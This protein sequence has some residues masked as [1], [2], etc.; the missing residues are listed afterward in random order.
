MAISYKNRGIAKNRLGQYQK[1]LL[2]FNEAYRLNSKDVSILLELAFARYRAQEYN[3]AIEVATE[4][5]AIKPNSA[6]AYYIRA[7]VYYE[8]SDNPA[9]A[10]ADFEKAYSL[11]IPRD[12]KPLSSVEN[13]GPV[14]L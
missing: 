7:W 14:P 2:D 12:D 4:A 13:R 6:R 10:S 3:L 9:K 1:A 11:G 5:I 8:R